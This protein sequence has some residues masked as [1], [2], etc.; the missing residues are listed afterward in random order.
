MLYQAKTINWYL[1]VLF[2]I[3]I[4]KLMLWDKLEL[5]DKRKVAEKIS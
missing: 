3:Y 4:K 1:L 5:K 2:D